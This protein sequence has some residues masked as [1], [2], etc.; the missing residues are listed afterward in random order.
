M[1]D[2]PRSYLVAT[3]K[4][5]TLWRNCHHL[6][7]TGESLESFFQFQS[8]EVP[9]DVPVVNSILCAANSEECST[10]SA[11]VTPVSVTCSSAGPPKSVSPSTTVDPSPV[12]P[13]CRSSRGIKAPDRLYLYM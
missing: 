12:L 6:R 7:A 5:G 3:D 10:S 11:P 4:G 9:D 13:L 1:A 2:T 8:D